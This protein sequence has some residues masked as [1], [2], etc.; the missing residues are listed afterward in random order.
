MFLF[1][2]K[3]LS[4]DFCLYVIGQNPVTEPTLVARSLTLREFVP[5]KIKLC[6]KEKKEKV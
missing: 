2:K 1:K 4:S 3:F 5:N 6:Y